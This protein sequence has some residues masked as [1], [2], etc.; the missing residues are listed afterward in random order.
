MRARKPP[1]TVE[2]VVRHGVIVRITRFARGGTVVEASC[3]C[4]GHSMRLHSNVSCPNMPQNP[5]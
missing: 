4:F 2:Q 5:S 3:Q 1:F